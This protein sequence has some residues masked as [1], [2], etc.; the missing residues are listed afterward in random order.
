L[1]IDLEQ[2]RVGQPEI[3]HGPLG[4]LGTPLRGDAFGDGLGREPEQFGD[5]GKLAEALG[6]CSGWEVDKTSP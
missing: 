3:A 2:E 4:V 6:Q 1:A 5:W